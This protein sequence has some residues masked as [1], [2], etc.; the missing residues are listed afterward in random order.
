MV[1]Y[2]AATVKQLTFISFSDFDIH[3]GVVRLGP[4]THRLRS[5]TA[6]ILCE[7]VSHTGFRRGLLFRDLNGN[8]VSHGNLGHSI[9]YSFQRYHISTVLDNLPSVLADYREKSHMDPNEYISSTFPRVTP[10]SLRMITIRDWKSR[11]TKKEFLKMT[12][13]TAR[14]YGS[15]S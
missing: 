5:D 15:I 4:V 2:Y 6:T 11:M 10:R 12:Q 7:Y 13:Y 14:H 3:R 9:T 8:Q 1:Y